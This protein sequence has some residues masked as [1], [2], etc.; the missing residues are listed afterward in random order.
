[1][2]WDTL[3][4][5]KVLH[6]RTPHKNEMNVR[7][8]V[9]KTVL[10]YFLPTDAANILFGLHIQGP[11]SC[12]PLNKSEAR[13]LQLPLP[14]GGA[15]RRVLITTPPEIHDEE[16]EMTRGERTALEQP[17]SGLTGTL[18]ALRTASAS[19]A[20]HCAPAAD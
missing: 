14:N 18:K 7:I 11:R 17:R 10:I 3:N 13:T 6:V 12:A 19:A 15:S 5:D 9:S 2:C 20:P 16:V 4:I 1:M 8:K